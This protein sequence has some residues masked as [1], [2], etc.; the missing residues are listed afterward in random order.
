[1]ERDKYG[2]HINNIEER[3]K[4]NQKLILNY[5]L[6]IESYEDFQNSRGNKVDIPLLTKVMADTSYLYKMEYK[7]SQEEML[8]IT[9]MLIYDYNNLMELIGREYFD[10]DENGEVGFINRF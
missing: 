3:I 5:A 2:H 8:K 4:K 9:D 10:I 1:M 6:A 7:I